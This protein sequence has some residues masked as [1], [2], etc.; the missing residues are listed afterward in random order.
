M[1]SV[2]EVSGDTRSGAAVTLIHVDPTREMAFTL[3]HIFIS[4]TQSEQS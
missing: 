2:G 4:F 3:F 1:P